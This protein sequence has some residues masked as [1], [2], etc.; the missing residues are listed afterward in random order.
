M[1]CA[2]HHLSACVRE[3]L[4]HAG[5]NMPLEVERRARDTL[6]RWGAQEGQQCA[7]EPCQVSDRPGTLRGP[8]SRL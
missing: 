3:L 7:P 5:A 1:A 2:A 8:L 6:A 4:A